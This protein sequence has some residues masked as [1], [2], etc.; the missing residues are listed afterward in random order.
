[1]FL[2]LNGENV[3]D[4][5]EITKGNLI[6]RGAFG[7]VFK[8][9]LHKSPDEPRSVAMKMLQ[10][11]QP[12]IRTGKVSTGTEL[13]VTRRNHNHNFV[14]LLQSALMA[15]KAALE[16]WRRDPLQH[17]CKAYFTARQELTV[18]LNLKH[19]NIMSLIG[20]C[21]QPLALIL[22]CAPYGALDTII[23]KY[24]RCG[25]RIGPYCFQLVVLQISRAIEYL[26]R[27]HII[28]RD[29]KAENVLVWNIPEPTE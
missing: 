8:A 28:Y 1:M 26:H 21:M 25:S 23:Q 14:S 11:V 16:K 12:G 22:D 15:Y 19:T 7:F 5:S 29:L 3:I 6:G 17:S 2:D 24:R 20:V 10:P 4:V 13:H 18:M 27:S 9:T